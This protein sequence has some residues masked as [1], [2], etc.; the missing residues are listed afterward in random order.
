MKRNPIILFAVLYLI[1]FLSDNF[2]IKAWA[3][4]NYVYVYK[5][6]GGSLYKLIPQPD[7]VK[8][9]LVRRMEVIEPGAILEIDKDASVTLTCAGCSILYLT[10]KNNPYEVKMTDFK[11]DRTNSTKKLREYFIDALGKFIDPSELGQQIEIKVR[12]GASNSCKNFLPGLLPTN[13]ILFPTENHVT[14]KWGKRGT[15]LLEIKEGAGNESVYSEET[16]LNS[17]EVAAKK[18]NPGRVYKWSL[19]EKKS[20]QKC[21]SNF[22]LLSKDESKELEKNMNDIVTL[23]PDNVDTETKYR[24][25]AGYLRFNDLE[26]DAWNWLKIHGVSQDGKE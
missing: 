4:E 16:S 24:L 9:K 15:T 11:K 8:R 26:Y 20:G 7:G 10:H 18:F 22:Q 1:L 5:I 2:T 13:K 6:E 25:Q 23:L 14:F 17:L 3:L 21:E 19:L 12:A